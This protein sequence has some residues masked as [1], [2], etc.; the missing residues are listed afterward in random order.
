MH[1]VGDQ[2]RLLLC[3]KKMHMGKSYPVNFVFIRKKIHICTNSCVAN[4]GV[5]VLISVN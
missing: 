4:A 5:C 1:Q 2:P 3:H